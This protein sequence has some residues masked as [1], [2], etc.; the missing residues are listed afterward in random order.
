MF[1]QQQHGSM[2]LVLTPGVRNLPPESV[3][4]S[5]EEGDGSGWGTVAAVLANQIV[6]WWRTVIADLG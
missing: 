1:M 5:E 6:K 4:V 3:D 2:V